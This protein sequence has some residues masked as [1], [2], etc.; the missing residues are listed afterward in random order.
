MRNKRKIGLFLVT[1][2]VMLGLMLAMAGVAYAED[3]VKAVEYQEASWDDT[4]KQV[5]YT[6]KSI[7]TYTKITSEWGGNYLDPG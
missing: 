5:V 1:L 6:T 4:N 3:A 2:V 7:S